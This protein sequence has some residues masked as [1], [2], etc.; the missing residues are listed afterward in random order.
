MPPC[1]DDETGHRNHDER[2]AE[3]GYVVAR[4]REMHFSL[5]QI[6]HKG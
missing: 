5:S 4:L 1:I 6:K 2:T 3:R